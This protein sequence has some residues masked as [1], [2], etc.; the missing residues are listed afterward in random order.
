MALTFEMIGL[1]MTDPRTLA[2]QIGEHLART[3]KDLG[4]TQVELA[5]RVN[6]SQQLIAEY[7]AGRK[8]IP[9]WR[10]VNL[11]EALGIEIEALLSEQDAKPLKRGPTPK[12]Q[13]QLEKISAL[14]KE[15]QKSIMQVLDMA[16]KPTA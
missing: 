16:L 9:L 10:L 12:L 14:P 1:S 15:Q 11:A 2:K 6:L 13:K 7:E 4:V 5:D 3:R 8:N